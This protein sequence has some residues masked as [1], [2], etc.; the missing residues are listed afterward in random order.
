MKINAYSSNMRKE[1]G[2]TLLSITST[3]N[4]PPS[5]LQ[6][7]AVPQHRISISRQEHAQTTGYALEQLIHLQSPITDLAASYHLRPQ[8]HGHGASGSLLSPSTGAA[9]P[10][11]P[12]QSPE[13]GVEHCTCVIPQRRIASHRIA[14]TPVLSRFTPT[15]HPEL[16]LLNPS[17]N[18]TYNTENPC[19]LLNKVRDSKPRPSNAKVMRP[20]HITRPRKQAT[21]L[22]PSAIPGLHAQTGQ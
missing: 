5:Y 4:H 7:A 20:A 14:S 17:H 2:E 9:L 11:S 18:K 1:E 3:T 8:H 21:P 6:T 19:S 15:L 10:I 16:H 13:P 12:E 22:Q